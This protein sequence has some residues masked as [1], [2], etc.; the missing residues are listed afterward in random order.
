MQQSQARPLR[1]GGECSQGA[2]EKSGGAAASRLPPP[3][4]SIFL[5]PCVGPRGFPAWSQEGWKDSWCSRPSSAPRQFGSF[6]QVPT[7]LSLHFP[8]KWRLGT[9]EGWS[10]GGPSVPCLRSHPAHHLLCASGNASP[11]PCLLPAH[12]FSTCCLADCCWVTGANRTVIQPLSGHPLT[13]TVGQLTDNRAGDRCCED[14][15]RGLSGR[16][17]K[18]THVQSFVMT[19]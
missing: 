2:S 9:S 7:S 3:I 16:E 6:G 1:T 4:P 10:G 13:G 5:A 19:P 8:E 17:V 14:K 18:R 15:G 11:T 12:L